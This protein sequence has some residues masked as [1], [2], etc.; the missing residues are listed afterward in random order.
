MMEF[1]FDNPE[2]I[3]HDEKDWQALQFTWEVY[4]CIDKGELLVSFYSNINPALA[5]KYIDIL[6][7]YGLKGFSLSGNIYPKFNEKNEFEEMFF[8][9]E[10]DQKY[11]E[12]VYEDMKKKIDFIKMIPTAGMKQ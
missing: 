9:D 3:V 11:H 8:D 2:M 4:F 7:R 6:H 5:G 12:D 1:E 10:A